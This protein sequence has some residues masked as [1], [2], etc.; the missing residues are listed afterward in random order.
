M[1]LQ[2]SHL[3]GAPSSK[4]TLITFFH[5][6]G[7]LS[8]FQSLQIPLIRA[9]KW[10][11]RGCYMVKNRGEKLLLP[12]KWLTVVLGAPTANVS[13]WTIERIATN[14]LMRYMKL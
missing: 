12:L 2:L 9:K 1:Y 11:F 3:T 13:D 7:K 6:L 4:S 14:S 5:S 10:D 8:D